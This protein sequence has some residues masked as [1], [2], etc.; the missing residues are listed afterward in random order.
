MDLD[1]DLD[2]DVGTGTGATWAL[3]LAHTVRVP[4]SQEGGQMGDVWA[5]LKRVVYK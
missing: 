5:S 3:A 4:E 1:M 2:L